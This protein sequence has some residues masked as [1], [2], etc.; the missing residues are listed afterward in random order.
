MEENK[1]VIDFLKEEDNEAILDLSH[2]CIQKGK[3]SVYPD[4]SPK[5]NRIHKQIDPE[6][7]HMV[8]RRG[9]RIIGCFGVVYTPVQYK[10]QTYRSSYV[11]DFKVDPEFQKGMTAYR[12][13]R[14]SLAYML[15]D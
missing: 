8:A 4:R 13:S 5:F 10:G 15:E 7:F 14:K 9:K 11:L 1:L 3:I 12:L 6:S 2:R